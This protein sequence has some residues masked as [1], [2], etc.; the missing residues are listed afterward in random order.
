MSRTI[1]VIPVR[2]FQT[3]KTR[4]SSLFTAD[5][6]G[7]LVRLMLD[8]V[9]AVIER[10]GAVDHELIV[11][12]DPAA[13]H[14]QLMALE[15][16][17]ILAQER[18]GKGLN[19]A[20]DLGRNWAIEHGFW[21]MLV[22]LPDLPMLAPSDIRVLVTE[23]AQVVI[24]QD[25]HGSGTNAVML[26]LHDASRRLSLSFGN[27]SAA[28][29]IAEAERLGLSWVTVDTTGLQYDLDTPYDWTTLPRSV[30]ADLRACIGAR[31]PAICVGE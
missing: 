7:R 27:N 10:S 15:Q 2:D 20:L 19:T 29:H 3:S 8:H 11:T 30:R 13:V 6:R 16:R 4:L 22:I 5:E 21:A 14:N 17:S 28:R 31:E 25:R 18:E 12:R 1:A 24:A 9:L 26:P 23:R